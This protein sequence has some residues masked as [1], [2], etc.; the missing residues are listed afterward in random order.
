MDLKALRV[1]KRLTQQKVAEKALLS[2]AAYAHI[3]NSTRRPSAEV[4]QRIAKALGFS[5]KWYKLLE[6]KPVREKGE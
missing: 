2:R 1:K 5:S 3:E 6:K 4:A